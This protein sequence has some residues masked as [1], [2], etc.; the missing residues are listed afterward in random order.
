MCVCVSQ[1]P[2]FAKLVRSQL[3][4]LGV[5]VDISISNEVCESTS[6]YRSLACNPLFLNHVYFGCVSCFGDGIS[7]FDH[8]FLR[9]DPVNMAT[10]TVNECT[11]QKKST[12]T[13]QEDAKRWDT[14]QGLRLGFVCWCF[15]TSEPH[16]SCSWKD[17]YHCLFF[18][19]QYIYVSRRC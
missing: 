13:L 11:R 6:K 3:Q 15:V 1:G 4:R 2:Q 9:V 19:E 10:V 8:L 12:H 7:I 17:T 14:V 16:S 5:I 18:L